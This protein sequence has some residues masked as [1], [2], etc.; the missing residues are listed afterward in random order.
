[1]LPNP[2]G[3]GLALR[4]AHYS[5]LLQ[6]TPPFD[7]L[8]V[9]TENF[10]DF[11]GNHFD[12]LTK[13]MGKTPL[14]PHGIC[15]NIGSSDPLDLDYLKR[16]K[17]MAHFV[18]APWFS[19]HLAW[20]KFNGIYYHEQFPLPR[21]KKVVAF[22]V[23]RA[24]FIQDFVG[25]PFALENVPSFITYPQDEMSCADFVS[26]IVEKANIL[27]LLDV[28]NLYL[29]SLTLKFSAQEFC[30]NIPMNRVIQFHLDGHVENENPKEC[31]HIWELF[32]EIQKL[33]PQASTLIEWEDGKLPSFDF[34]CQE[35]LKL[36]KILYETASA[37]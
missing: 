26:E 10:L 17:K 32:L 18:K 15:L 29:S 5:Q 21:T 1:M 28:K 24:K 13:M 16:L 22:I 34:A 19:D 33:S 37:T 9:M 3:V 36:K 6:T 11:K 25:L 27:L 30:Q 7:W 14:I 23:E 2:L 31:H 35:I 20:G 12:F 4:S 8:E